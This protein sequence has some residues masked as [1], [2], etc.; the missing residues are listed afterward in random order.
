MERNRPNIDKTVIQGDMELNVSLPEPVEPIEMKPNVW[1]H[2]PQVGEAVWRMRRN[3]NRP[4][5]DG[6]R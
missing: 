6:K 3:M 5:R 2:L 1:L 4:R